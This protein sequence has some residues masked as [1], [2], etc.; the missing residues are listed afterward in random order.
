MATDHSVND[1]VQNTGFRLSD[2]WKNHSM[3]HKQ[4]VAVIGGGAIGLAP[5]TISNARGVQS[6]WWIKDH[7]PRMLA[8]HAAGL[9]VAQPFHT[10]WHTPV[11]LRRE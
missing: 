9:P 1:P 7:R 10:P 8:L 6:P 5:H 3:N 11:S 4:Q 2:I